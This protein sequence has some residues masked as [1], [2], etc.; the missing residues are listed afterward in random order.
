MSQDD[1][2]Q[3]D[4]P[5]RPDEGD[6]RPFT[7]KVNNKPVKIVGHVHTGLEIKQAAIAQGV[8][9]AEDFVLSEELSHGRMRIVGDDERVKLTKDSRFEAIPNDDHS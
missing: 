5:D 9:I 3:K 8:K 4:P 6:D 1:K 2:G 7:I